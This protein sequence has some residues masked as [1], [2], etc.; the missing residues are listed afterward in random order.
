MIKK[1]LL[2]LLFLAALFIPDKV[3]AYAPPVWGYVKTKTGVPIGGIAVKWE[4]SENNIRYTFTNPD[5]YFFYSSYSLLPREKREQMYQTMIDTDHDGV[6]ESRECN[7]IPE[8]RE[9]DVPDGFGCRQNPHKITAVMPKNWTGGFSAPP[10]FE[11]IPGNK[12]NNSMAE[13]KVVDIIYDP[14]YRPPPSVTATGTRPPNITVTPASACNCENM[15]VSDNLRTGEQITITTRA[16]SLFPDTTKVGYMIYRV[17]K[18]GVE[19][20]KSKTIPAS[21]IFNSYGRYET[22]WKYRLPQGKDSPGNYHISAQIVCAKKTASL[23]KPVSAQ[24]YGLFPSVTVI[25]P[26]GV[27]SL[28]LGTFHPIASLKLGCKDM[29]FTIR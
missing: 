11:A 23:I 17:F 2:I 19:I 4:D 8:G 5:G 29:Y 3:E 28:Q 12:L 14:N 1:I 16:R 20:A 18:N 7:V 13:A 25:A 6:P 22:S 27:N 9:K 10:P 26:S 24:D 21:E 15:T